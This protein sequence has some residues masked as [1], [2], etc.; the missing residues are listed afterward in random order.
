MRNRIATLAAVT[1]LTLFL[2][3]A[4]VTR[5]VE[6]KDSDLN[7]TEKAKPENITETENTQEKTTGKDKVADREPETGE[8]PTDKDETAAQENNTP[9]G[10]EE[11]SPKEYTLP[12]GHVSA[13][14]KDYQYA[15]LSGDGA[16]YKPPD[17]E[18]FF[19]D[20]EEAGKK[21]DEMFEGDVRGKK[22][23]WLDP[24]EVWRT[25]RQGWK[26]SREST[27]AKIRGQGR[28]QNPDSIEILYHLSAVIRLKRESEYIIPS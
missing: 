6:T 16:G 17:Y 7:T 18:G 2:G 27:K 5:S 20:D 11:I 26:H 14:G 8:K 10:K 22:I 28:W 24:D 12:E 25:V 23:K 9:T 21:L 19:P 15:F 4:T 3:G 1:A 13:F